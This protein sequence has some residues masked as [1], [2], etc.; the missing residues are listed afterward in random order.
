MAEKGRTWTER[1]TKLLLQ[2]WSKD[3]IQRQLQ[4]V[5]RNNAVYQTIADELARH[6]MSPKTTVTSSALSTSGSQIS[7]DEGDD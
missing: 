2:I 3:R 4:G 1:E 6:G 7:T 5:V